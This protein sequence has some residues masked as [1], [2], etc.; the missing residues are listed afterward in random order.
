LST[1]RIAKG[2]NVSAELERVGAVY[3]IAVKGEQ[4]DARPLMKSAFSPSTGSPATGQD[5]DIDLKIASLIGFNSEILKSADIRAQLRGGLVR[6]LKLAGNL[7]KQAVAGQMAKGEKGE[8]VIVLESADAGA[9]LR[10]TDISSS[11]SANMMISSMYISQ[12]TYCSPC[13]TS[14]C[15]TC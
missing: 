2:D 7:A 10:F 3:R 13:N 15:I 8:P 11:V 12:I 9:L 1:L 5:F 4:F 6:D 14:D